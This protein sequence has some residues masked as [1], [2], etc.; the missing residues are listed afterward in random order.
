[1]GQPRLNLKNV[2]SLLVDRDHY[3][4]GLIAQM[5]RGFRMDP[6]AF[7]DNGEE[8]KKFLKENQPNICLIEGD[9]ADMSSA[10]LICW[11]RRQGKNPLRFVPIIVMSGYTQLRMISTVRDGGAHI[12][13]RKPIS[14][15]V[16]FDRI[17]W[18][19]RNTRPFLET[20]KYIGPDRRF[21][22][23][24][25]PDGLFKREAEP[26]ESQQASGSKP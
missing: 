10:D 26:T 7:A 20:D 16:L 13:A 15:Q 1:M 17:L 12:V 6:P 5:L 4:R 24:L 8:A 19:A 22:D 3:T 9:L 2:S 14:P 23:I 18:V 25:P 11:I 21:H